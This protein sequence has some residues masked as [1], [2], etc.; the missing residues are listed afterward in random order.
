MN[1]KLGNLQHQ[2]VTRTRASTVLIEL[3]GR[4]KAAVRDLDNLNYRKMKKILM[5][6]EGDTAGGASEEGKRDSV[7]SEHSLHSVAASVASTGSNS[8][9]AA[10]EAPPVPPHAASTSDDDATPHHL[11]HQLL[12]PRPHASNFATIRTT[13]IVTKQQKEHMQEEMHEQMSGYKRM[14]REHQGA[15]LKLE[16]RCK[17][18]CSKDLIEIKTSLVIGWG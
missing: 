14:R 4:T 1:L 3:I 18:N 8:S 5:A 9:L 2:L 6:D 17:V 11:M 13:S 10:A 15:L 16:E 12:P 7:T